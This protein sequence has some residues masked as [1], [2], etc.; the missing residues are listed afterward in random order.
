MSP[1]LEAMEIEVESRSLFGSMFY[2]DRG[3]KKMPDWA[4]FFLRLG[5]AVAALQ[6][7]S[8]RAMVAVTVPHRGYAAALIATGVVAGRSKIP[9]KNRTAVEHFHYLRLLENGTP[10]RL[11]EG[12]RRRLRGRLRGLSRLYGEDL[13]CVQTTNRR[14]GSQKHYVP[15]R[16]SFRIEKEEDDSGLSTRQTGTRVV[17]VSAFA[18][19][20]LSEAS[21]DEG[22]LRSRLDCVILGG[23]DALRR[24]ISD[25]AFACSSADDKLKEGKL[26]E[27]LRV[28]KFMGPNKAY[29]SSALGFHRKRPPEVRGVSEPPRV[30]VFDGASGFLKWRHRWPSSDWVIVLDR[31]ERRFDDAVS[32][33]NHR[34]LS[35]RVNDEEL[36]D[37]DLPPGIELVAFQESAHG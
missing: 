25:T 18:A 31:G 4:L 27:I 9:A 12:K 8:V 35:L 7:E 2:D 21:T 37:L 20:F 1:G 22:V 3:W 16:D 34:Y 29:R 28:R 24:E 23:L 26:N 10:V 17:P 15:A 5:W 14:G 11:L 30:I 36:V 19:H 6:A 33:V 13:I 32:E